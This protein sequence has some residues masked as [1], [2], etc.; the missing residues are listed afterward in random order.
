MKRQ[1][2]SL[3]AILSGLIFMVSTAVPSAAQSIS[4]E[5]AQVIAAEAYVYFYPLVTMDL[6]RKQLINSDPKT[7]GIGGP[8]NTF[9]NIQAYP[10]ADMRSVVRPNFDT[11]YSSAWLDL[12]R[13]PLVVSAPDTGGRYYLLPMLDMWTDVF[14]SPGWRTTGTKAAN[15]LVVPP[16][17]TG[18][19]PADFARIDAPTPYVWIIGRTKTDGPADYAAVHEVQKGYK[20]TPLSGWGKPPVAVTQ[21][22]DPNVD[23]KTPPKQQVDTMAGDKFFAYAA[24]L[25]KIHPPHITDQPI[26]AR[27][28]RIGLEPGKRFDI[29][30]VDATVR[31]A[32]EEAPAQ[33]QKLMAWKVPTLARVANH[34]SMNTDTMGVYGNYYLKRAIVAQ[35]GLGANLPEDAIYPGSIGDENGK[36]LDG[37]NK[38]I[39]RFAKDALPPV[40]A[41]WSITLYDNDG[42][43]V[44]NPVNRFAVSSWMPFK[45]DADGSLTIYFQNDNPGGDRE[46]NWLPAPKGP[47]NLT[48]RLYAP[49][50]DALT[51]VWNPPGIKRV[52]SETVGRQQ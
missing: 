46:A 8:P 16:G 40:E 17:W 24:E 11:L 2:S 13:E 1:L 28:A 31:K 30:K 34:W 18:S 39:I 35:V 12:T 49:K 7:A 27:M 23:V 48:M 36:P 25:T 51:G 3:A 45:R 52:D 42:F 33:A 41:F 20:I 4:A 10:T 29:S 14:A 32:V 38:Y 15:F 47:F 19:V 22:I 9:D 26:I 37:A 44:A 50:S 6:T 43:Q 5:E 21:T